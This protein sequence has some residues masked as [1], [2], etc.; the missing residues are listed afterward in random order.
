MSPNDCRRNLGEVKNDI[1]S[2]GGTN[3]ENRHR[4]AGADWI[5]ARMGMKKPKI[6]KRL[7][8]LAFSCFKQM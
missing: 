6:A 1:D 5:G 8:N 4:H 3:C 7:R 2:V